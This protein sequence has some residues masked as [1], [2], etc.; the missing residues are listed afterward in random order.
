[1]KKAVQGLGLGGCWAF[2]AK[3]AT[4]A[5][6]REARLLGSDR[7]V[8]EGP[9][10]MHRQTP[11]DVGL[12]YGKKGF[13]LH[14]LSFMIYTPNVLSVISASIG[15]ACPP[16]TPGSKTPGLGLFLRAFT[17]IFI[18]ESQKCLVYKNVDLHLLVSLK[19][20]SGHTE[21]V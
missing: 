3:R 15:Y 6:D 21:L 20:L 18:W 10:T 2:Q 13:S 4:K 8:T 14:R 5:K 9:L 19:S 12:W 16:H 11:E 1:M 17:I 7:L